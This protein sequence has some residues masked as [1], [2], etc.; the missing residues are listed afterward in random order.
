MIKNNPTFESPQLDAVMQHFDRILEIPR[1]SGGERQIRQHI[2]DIVTAKGL[3]YKIDKKGNL[4]IDVLATFGCEKKTRVILQGHMDM[5]TIGGNETKPT[6]AYLEDGWLSTRESTTLGADNGLGVAMALALLDDE[7]VQHGPLTL[8]FTVDEETGLTGATNLGADLLPQDSEIVLINLDSEEGVKYICKGCAGGVDVVGKMNVEETS[9]PEGFEVL[10]VE[11]TGLLGGHSGIDIHLQRGNAIQTLNK[12]LLGLSS[13]LKRR[14]TNLMLVDISGGTKRNAI[15]SN[16]TCRLAVR[17]DLAGF[18]E[19]YL[20]GGI[21]RIKGDG[22][23]DLGMSKE[24]ATGISLN[25]EEVA[26]GEVTVFKDGFRQKIQAVIREICALEIVAD[27]G[28]FKG[29]VRLSNNL[30]VLKREGNVFELVTMVRGAVAERMDERAGQ[31]K[32]ILEKNLVETTTRS[33]YEGWLEDE[34]SPAVQVAIEAVRK[35]MG[36][37]EGVFAYHAGLESAYVRDLIRRTS[38]TTNVSAV[39]I[40]PRIV[41]AHSVKERVRVNSVKD[42]YAVLK[43]AL[44]KLAA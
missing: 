44:A 10:N 21:S 4:S 15:P 39:S 17:P 20:Q 6:T 37:E 33:R 3:Q 14:D 13:E 16:A 11:L 42:T 9:V 25:V 22:D 23:D 29:G 27:K 36:Q 35:V 24:S 30:G 12:L 5:F 28:G 8:L 41:D 34:D 32:A 38:P 31:I 18:I 43:T 19:E 40:G 26:L 1:P 7:D 2:V